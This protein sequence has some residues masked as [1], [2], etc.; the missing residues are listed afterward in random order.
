MALADRVKR[1]TRDVRLTTD[2]VF[3]ALVMMSG[4]ADNCCLNAQS[5]SKVNIQ[6][7]GTTQRCGPSELYAI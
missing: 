6:S 2:D 1:R 5:Q 4:L 3:M 7:E